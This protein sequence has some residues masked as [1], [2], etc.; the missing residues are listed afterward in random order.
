M[1]RLGRVLLSILL[2]VPMLVGMAFLSPNSALNAPQTA[3][4][5][6]GGANSLDSP[7][8]GK[9]DTNS[10]QVGEEEYVVTYK[11]YDD[12]FTDLNITKETITEADLSGNGS[13]TNPYIVRST[14]GFLWLSKNAL[15]NKYIELDCDVI[16][17]EEKF[18]ENGTPSGGDGRVYQ[19]FPIEYTADMLIDGKEHSISGLF[20][21]HTITEEVER[22]YYCGLFRAQVDTIK[23]LIVK[24]F[25][26]S[27]EN[28]CYV[29]PFPS[30]NYVYNCKSYG[31]F[32][33]GYHSVSGLIGRLFKEVKYCENHSTVLA[34]EDNSLFVGGISGDFN[35][36]GSKNVKFCDNYGTIR[37]QSRVAGIVGGSYNSVIQV[38]IE[39]CNNYG[40][41]YSSNSVAAGILGYMFGESMVKFC[42]NYG[43]ID[44]YAWQGGGI[45]G[46]SAGGSGIRQ[47]LDCNNYGR[48]ANFRD[49]RRNGGIVGEVQRSLDIVRCN[50]LSNVPAK[51]GDNAGYGIIVG[52]LTPYKDM[53]VRIKDCKGA[54]DY[55]S[56]IIAGCGKDTAKVE[57]FIENCE[58]DIK[59]ADRIVYNDGNV[60]YHLKNIKVNFTGEKYSMSLLNN[61][62]TGKVVIEDM[63]VNVKCQTATSLDYLI[64]S[65]RSKLGTIIVDCLVFDFDI[66]GTKKGYFFGND[67]SNY[68][69]D[70]KTGEIGLKATS[71]NGFH[72]GRVTEEYLQN[73]GFEKKMI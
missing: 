5:G 18:D 53:I 67:F 51:L 59:T 41:V 38:A 6:G 65:S 31:G 42:N 46:Y 16:L 24:D 39:N 37:G 54:C 2:L 69:V 21:D 33:K 58:V 20:I 12:Y 40:K 26:L 23:N 19:W 35:Q 73:R 14:K 72:Q 50:D 56:R 28:G 15:A 30:V 17:N 7:K 61:I 63:F 1:K 45:V 10:N 48:V 43:M 64:F 52:R 4:N 11:T 25:Y 47:I 60:E 66:N 22:V 8:I 44:A 68:F 27:T 29:A 57:V 9:K 13:A 62:S 3:Q 49:S 32:T 55:S 71:G 70:F 36:A 34:N